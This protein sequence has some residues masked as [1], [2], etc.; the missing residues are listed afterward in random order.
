MEHKSVEQL[1]H[2]ATVQPAEAAHS[3]SAIQRLERWAEL[4]ESNLGARLRTFFET[5]HQEPV[6]RDAMRIDGSPV[7][8]AFA[9]PILR[10]EGLAADTYGEAKRF[11]GVSDDQLHH[12]LCYCHHGATISA[13]TA[14]RR[15]RGLMASVTGAAVF[16]RMRPLFL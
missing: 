1:T 11:F 16:S 6:A 4:L 2:L 3:M 12:L 15:I 8:I 14:A 7:S 10:A 5:E 9:D 13:D